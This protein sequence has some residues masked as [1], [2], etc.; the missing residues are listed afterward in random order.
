MIR[1]EYDSN[2]RP[3]AENWEDHL[4]ESLK[5]PEYAREYLNAALEEDDYRV[6]LLALRHVATAFGIKYVADE[7]GLNRENIYK[8]LS[9]NGNPRIS[10]LIGLLRAVGVRLKTETAEPAKAP[11]KRSTP[12]PKATRRPAVR[13]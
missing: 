2:G 8:M 5:D 6:F 4:V 11:R 10:S 12:K 7:A 13:V 3:Y 9:S 1:T